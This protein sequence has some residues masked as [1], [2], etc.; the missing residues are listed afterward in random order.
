MVPAH[1]V[2][3]IGRYELASPLASGGMAAVHLGRA[4][5]AQGFARVVV[6]KRI[7]PAFAHRSDFVRMFVN[8]ARLAARVRHPNVVATLDAVEHDDELLLVMEFV[9][10]VSLATLQANTVGRIPI[11]IGAAIV[12]GALR[13]LHA[14]HEARDETGRPLTIVHRD[15]S[16]QNVLVGRDGLP[17][18]LDF[19]VAKAASEASSLTAHGEFKGKLTYAAP[20]QVLFQDV[21]PQ[22]DVFAAGLVLWEIATGERRYGTLSHAAIAKRLTDESVPLPSAVDPRLPRALD[23]IV[24]RATQRNPS[25]RYASAAEMARAIE[26]DVGVATPA[27][28][29]AWLAQTAAA[30]LARLERLV[31]ACETATA[32]DRADRR[33]APGSANEGREG[34]EGGS[35]AASALAFTRTETSHGEPPARSRRGRRWPVPLFAALLGA[36]VVIVIAALLAPPRGGR[37]RPPAP[38]ATE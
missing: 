25:F 19:G 9:D 20:E 12:A 32:Y 14:A 37:G 8:E 23:R 3:R 35:S 28:V 21:S 36:L 22:T 29:A 30:E 17:R 31:A 26:E 38:V 16:P 1:G 34:G 18:V 10:G 7:L 2:L 5:G 33:A 24:Y 4:L 15:V 27:E 11:A 13:G 6:I